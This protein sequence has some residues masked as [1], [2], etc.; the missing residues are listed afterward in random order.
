MPMGIWN[1]K[2][3]KYI[4][5]NIANPNAASVQNIGENSVVTMECGPP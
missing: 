5:D 1:I 2:L 4:P 3:R